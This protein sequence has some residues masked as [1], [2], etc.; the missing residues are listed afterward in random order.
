M[1]LRLIISILF[2]VILLPS[3]TAG[4]SGFQQELIRVALFKGVE[5][6]RLDGNGILATDEN[7]EPLR[8]SFPLEISRARNGISVNGSALRGIKV[9]APVFVSV[10]GKGYRGVVEISAA[11]KGLQV[12]NELPLEDYLVG[13]INC[14]ISSQWPME[15]VKAQAVIARSYAIFQRDARKGAPYHL[16]S[17]VM[18]QVY[19]GCDIEDSRAARGVKETAGEVLTF[20]GAIIQAFY[21]SNC[22]GHTEASEN[23]WGY[24]LPYLTGVTCRYCQNV[25]SYHWDQKI[26]LKKA[27]AQLKAAGFNISGLRDIRLGARNNSGRITV[28]FLSGTRGKISVPAVAF[29]KALGYSV[30]KSTNFDV[31][32]EDDNLLISGNGNGHG[33]GLCQWGAKQRAADGFDYREILSYYYPGTRVITLADD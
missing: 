9:S 28:L 21:H 6:V 5:S 8:L 10:N 20:N 4:N 23:V 22:G 13:L 17:T 33:V 25:N 1:I 29:R 26:S 27:E 30:I 24:K 19:E 2:L 32:V 14:E 15:A 31:R 3:M 12:V 16:E 18:D 11:E 7:G